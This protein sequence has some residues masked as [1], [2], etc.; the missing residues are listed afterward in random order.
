MSIDVKLD[1]E[2]GEFICYN[3]TRSGDEKEITDLYNGMKTEDVLRLLSQWPGLG[4]LSYR[5]PSFSHYVTINY[6]TWDDNLINGF[7]IGFN[8]KEVCLDPKKKQSELL[9]N[10]ISQFVDY[11]FV[12]GNIYNVIDTSNRLSR[13][14][15]YIEKTTFEF[16]KRKNTTNT[17][18]KH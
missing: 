2:D 13:I 7:S 17:M 6:L 8:G 11:R 15:K 10:K 5:H 14:V 3:D 16:D 4:I 9:I 1:I 18:K 12:V